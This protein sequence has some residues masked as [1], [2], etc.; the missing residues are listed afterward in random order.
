M[1]KILAVTTVIA[2]GILS[3]LSAFAQYR[4]VE[5][6]AV[7][8]TEAQLILQEAESSETPVIITLEQA[9]EIALSENV[10]VKVADMEIERT[11]YAKKG[12]YAAL[13][14]QIDI[15]G[16]YQRFTICEVSFFSSMVYFVAYE[17]ALFLLA[18][19][20]Y[21]VVALFDNAI[22]VL[23]FLFCRICLLL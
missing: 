5:E 14:P 3:P 1:K 23:L 9:L 17:F 12:S 16:A 2:A 7:P 8:M 11:G 19:N 18:C 20:G 15:S 6:E 22:F 21:D 10:S 13:F 4:D